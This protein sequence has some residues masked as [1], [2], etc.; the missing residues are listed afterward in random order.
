M[1]EALQGRD[2]KIR[3]LVDSSIIG[4]V[5][6]DLEGDVLEANDA[7]LTLVGYDRS[8]LDGGRMDWKNITPPEFATR[9]PS[10]ASA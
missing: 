8:D 2:A 6:S 1:A 4:M 9:D 10:P 7:F 3:R 5:I